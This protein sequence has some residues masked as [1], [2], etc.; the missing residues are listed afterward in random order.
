MRSKKN[1]KCGVLANWNKHSKEKESD[2]LWQMVLTAKYNKD[3]EL[4]TE[5]NNMTEIKT[6][7]S[8]FKEEWVVKDWNKKYR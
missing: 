8:V 1:Y 2:R 3:R 6:W 4:T 5:L 7:L